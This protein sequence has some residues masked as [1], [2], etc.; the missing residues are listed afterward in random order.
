M[1][2]LITKPLPDLSTS[3]MFGHH[4]KPLPSLSILHEKAGAAMQD[5]Q[6]LLIDR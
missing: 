5:K 6:P 2:E 4:T 1:R 3:H